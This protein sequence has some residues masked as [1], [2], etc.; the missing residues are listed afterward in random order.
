MG[1]G[2]NRGN[3]IIMFIFC[4]FGNILSFFKVCNPKAMHSSMLVFLIFNIIDIYI[5]VTSLFPFLKFIYN[6]N[7]YIYITWRSSGGR[8]CV[9][10]SLCA[11]DSINNYLIIST[12]QPLQSGREKLFVRP[13]HTFFMNSIHLVR[14]ETDREKNLSEYHTNVQIYIYM[15]MFAT[16][17]DYKCDR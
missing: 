9:W 14:R 13:E 4:I 2:K 6:I 8:V 17:I 15:L 5:T 10:S 1:W 12:R 3:R 16:V 11:C 7:I